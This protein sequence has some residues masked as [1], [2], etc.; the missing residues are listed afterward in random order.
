MSATQFTKSPHHQFIES[1]HH[2][3]GKLGDPGE[4]ETK[5]IY[6]GKF[7]QGM[8]SWDTST[9]GNRRRRW[10]VLTTDYEHNVHLD[11]PGGFTAY[12]VSYTATDTFEGDGVC[13]QTDSPSDITGSACAGYVVVGGGTTFYRDGPLRAPTTGGSSV[14]SSSLTSRTWEGEDT[15]F[16]TWDET[17][18]QE[19]TSESTH[20]AALTACHDACAALS[21][22]SLDWEE[23]S[24]VH[25]DEYPA[26]AAVSGYGPNLNVSSLDPGDF[27]GSVVSDDFP[28]LELFAPSARGDADG[29]LNGAFWAALMPDTTEYPAGHYVMTSL[30]LVAAYASSNES[31][32]R[33]YAHRMAFR[34]S[35]PASY[36]IAEGWLNSAGELEDPALIT[37][38]VVTSLGVAIP[39][40]AIDTLTEGHQGRVAFAII[41]ETPAAW[42][43]RTGITL[44]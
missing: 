2:Q 38:G 19:L 6:A 39:L 34:S 4:L 43:T 22:D 20:S 13:P 1:P 40:P 14:T 15:T 31:S 29:R 21:F 27:D 8:H 30:W 28:G 10:L 24:G 23:F 9:V 37:T 41:G 25:F 42:E 18:T 11:C 35:K 32:D 36:F 7:W 33:I 5:Q 12:T 16:G 3:R 17:L 44:D 26:G